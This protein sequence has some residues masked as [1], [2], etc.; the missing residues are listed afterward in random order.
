MSEPKCISPLLD[1][2]AMGNPISEHDG[3]MC[4]PAIKENSDKKFIVKI[5]SVPASQ[6]QMDALLLAGAYRDPADAMEYFKDRAEDII[7]EAELLTKLSRLEG[8]LPYDG[9][10]IAP[11]TR[12]RLGYQ[13]Y[14]LGSYKRSLT[15]HLRRSPVTHL[16]AINLGL[17]ICSALSLCRQAGALYVD[18]KPNNIFMSD[19]KEYRIG[20]LG[21]IQL[22]ALS[23]STLPEKYRSAYTPPEFTDPLAPLNTTADTYALGMI[24]YQLYNDGQLPDLRSCEDGIPSTPA[25]A[26]YEI[27][28]IIMKAI[29]PDPEQRWENP[30]QMGH[31]LVSYMQRNSINDIP[32]T[33]HTP[34]EPA[35]EPII[36]PEK[37]KASVIPET[38]EITPA[39]EEEPVI[40]DEPEISEEAV[41]AEETVTAEEEVPAENPPAD[42]QM[43]AEAPEDILPEVVP[44][45]CTAMEDAIPSE[46]EAPVLPSFELSEELSRIVAKADDL[47]AHEMPEE[48]IF[49]EIPEL[50]DPFDFIETDPE[51]IDDSDVPLE[52]VMD[53]EPEETPATGKKKKTKRFVSPEHKR[54]VRRVISTIITLIV[55][56]GLG[57]GAYLYYD[58][59]YIQTI[60][61]IT[62][63][64]G[65]DQLTV[66]VDTDVDTA[67]L[68]VT[69]SDSYGNVVTQK[70]TEGKSTFGDLLP[71]TMY[72]IR[73]DI[74][75]FH[76]LTGKTTEYFTTDAN[77]R[78]VSFTAVTGPEDGSAVINFTADGEEPS[79]WTIVCTA[80]GEEEI[81]ETFEGH[82]VTIT[83]L[84]IGKTYT[85]SLLAENGLSIDGN[86]TIEFIAS[87]LILAQNLHVTSE[88]G[89][90]MTI[91]WNAPGGVIVDSWDVRCYNDRDFEQKF[92]VTEPS[93]FLAE[94]DPSAAYTIEIT[95]SGMTQPART[96]I[97]K[98]PINI[99][100]FH[101]ART[102]KSGQ[103]KLEIDWQFTGTEPRGGWLVMYTIDGSFTPNG[104]KTEKA[105]AQI[106]PYLPGAKYQI[107]IQ[108]SDGTSVFSNVH[109]IIT[110]EAK[111]FEKHSLS[112]DKL[113]V[114]LLK[115]PEL[116][117]WR[118]ENI[119]DKD[120]TDQ[121]VAGDKLSVVL[122]SSA[123]FYLPGSATKVMYVIRDAHGNVIPELVS[124][125]SVNWKDIW[126]GGD[127]KAGELDIPVSPATAGNYLLDIYFD[128]M[129]VAQLPFTV[130]A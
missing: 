46:E 80:E 93:A 67:L 130:T 35:A 78:I 36:P 64:G 117:D 44:E 30:S 33:P 75:G 83:G 34:L 92:T 56:A 72:T 73:V 125:E 17:D 5:I 110:P 65:K 87:R 42:V 29:H 19:K 2:F 39:A 28:E 76:K 109:T 120:F 71:N 66:S 116:K 61:G 40:S 85:F 68:Q 123:T 15:K 112:A 70:L 95:A 13:V 82:S 52:P 18:L 122:R 1:G 27:A 127:A 88:N 113:T 10:Q 53:E 96:T 98:N 89:N 4:C 118:Y 14:L 6:V 124:Q 24:L 128:G 16:E 41:T 31:A 63:E 43:P 7:K 97:T 57:F 77:I 119:S 86:N 99:S 3:V 9:W 54:R 25:N 32:I 104:M 103:E 47:I 49:P 94:T 55:L 91:H 101:S 129:S 37:K 62:I 22:D 84:T 79:R 8:F 50:P 114:K 126:S 60:Q 11:I 58:H 38:E 90:D 105:S 26:D 48:M 121:F 45:P 20:D 69:C 74:D 100:Q 59:F 106:E 107:T 12:H 23:Y 21:F 81:R 115:T 51:D 108:A 102:E 111:A